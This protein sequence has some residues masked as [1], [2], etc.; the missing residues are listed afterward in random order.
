METVAGLVSG[1]LQPVQWNYRH[2]HI[3]LRSSTWP[4][5]PLAM[6][7]ISISSFGK[8]GRK[9]WQC[10]AQIKWEGVLHVPRWWMVVQIQ[11]NKTKCGQSIQL[12]QFNLILQPPESHN[13]KIKQLDR[14]S[15]CVLCS[16]ISPPNCTLEWERMSSICPLPSPYMIGNVSALFRLKRLTLSYQYF[17]F[18]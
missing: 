3:D 18:S 13:I 1:W 14:L 7:S 17:H 10:T 11:R 2:L 15:S 5:T 8:S 12:I 6:L 16:K 4:M 9:E